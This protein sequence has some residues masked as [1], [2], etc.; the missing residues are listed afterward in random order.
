MNGSALPESFT[1][2]NLFVTTTT[3]EAEVGQVMAT[4]DGRLFRYVKNGAV[5]MTVGNV[6]QAPAQIT[7]HQ[8]LVPTATAVGSR[9][10]QVALGATA[11]T[12]NQYAGGWAIIDTTPGLGYAYPI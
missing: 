10:I 8:Q 2:G 12:A 5:A 3:R 6:Q 1:N 7:N 9:T 11:V 4:R